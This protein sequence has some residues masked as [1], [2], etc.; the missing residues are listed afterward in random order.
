MTY[1][2]KKAK[3]A[4]ILVGAA[5]TGALVPGASAH[6]GG[7]MPVNPSTA[8]VTGAVVKDYS[9]NSVSG[10]YVP[11]KPLASAH[12]I[13]T[14]PAANPKPSDDG[15]DVSLAAVGALSGTAFL[16]IA[17]GAAGAKARRGRQKAL[18]A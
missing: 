4:S 13:D 3:L 6:H 8:D 10:N 18:Q 7:S 17:V 12:V 14:A 2:A 15:S 16:L 5:L 1:S 11:A 9:K